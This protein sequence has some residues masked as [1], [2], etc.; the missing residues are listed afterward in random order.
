[1]CGGKGRRLGKLGE[2]IPKPLVE[3]KGKT[4]LEM[5]LDEYIKSGFYDF[6]LCTG[7]KSEMIR[8]AVRKYEKRREKFNFM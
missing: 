1:M 4:I 8:D 6:I 3:V 7:Y 2:K 5:K